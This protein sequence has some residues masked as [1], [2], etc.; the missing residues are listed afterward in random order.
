MED[1]DLIPFF[2][3]RRQYAQLRE[4]LLDASDQVYRSGQVLDGKQVKAFEQAIALRCNR[5][6]A[7]AVNSATQ[8]LIFALSCLTRIRDVMIPN[9]SFAATANSVSMAG[10]TARFVDTDHKG[11]INLSTIDYNIKEENIGAVMYVNLYGNVVDYDR[12]RVMTD[13]LT[14]TCLL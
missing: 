14:M 9:V 4:E 8:G 7:V 6:H 11:L 12:F 10:H 1:P 5:R 13:S 2:G 3:I